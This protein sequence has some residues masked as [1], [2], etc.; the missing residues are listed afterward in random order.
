MTVDPDG[1]RSFF[2]G[3][4][5]VKDDIVQHQG[6]VMFVD[7]ARLINRV[8]KYQNRG[9]DFSICSPNWFA[10]WS[11]WS[12][13]QEEAV[14]L[15]IQTNPPRLIASGEMSHEELL[16]SLS[17]TEK[18]LQNFLKFTSRT[19]EG[20]YVC[21]GQEMEI[22]AK[23]FATDADPDD[24]DVVEVLPFAGWEIRSFLSQ[25]KD[26]SSLKDYQK[27]RQKFVQDNLDN[28][29]N[30]ARKH[31]IT[32][33]QMMVELISKQ[34][35]RALSGWV[36]FSSTPSAKDHPDLKGINLAGFLP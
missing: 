31:R 26:C 7:N 15:D 23:S 34:R 33:A 30:M 27:K 20:V 35:A 25:N 24:C 4:E 36:L 22:C 19:T 8:E 2:F 29:I 12:A 17:D 18:R 13:A 3:D 16:A 21:G 32:R 5:Q 11:A 9:F 6:R 14:V 1:K 10:L 28:S